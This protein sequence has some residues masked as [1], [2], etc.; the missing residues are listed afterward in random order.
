MIKI[1]E[2]SIALH[3]E[4]PKDFSLGDIPIQYCQS[5]I[6]EVHLNVLKDEP[7]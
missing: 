6:T 4:V 1:I 5:L 7:W 3:A 2:K